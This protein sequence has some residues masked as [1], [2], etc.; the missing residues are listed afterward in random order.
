MQ[1][2]Q[3]APVHGAHVRGHAAPSLRIALSLPRLPRAILGTEPE[4]VLPRRA[5]WALSL[6]SSS[7]VGMRVRDRCSAE[8]R[9][10]EAPG[11]RSAGATLLKLAENN[12][13]IA[14]YEIAQHPRQ[15][16]RRSRRASRR[17]RSGWRERPITATSRP[18]TNLASALRDGRG[19]VQDYE[20][21][22]KWMQLAA[23]GGSGP[24]Q[25][26]LGMTY[27]GRASGSINNVKAYVWL[28]RCSRAGRAGCNRGA[29]RRVAAPYP[30][31]IAGSAAKCTACS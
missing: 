12:D 21:A 4:R 28:Q 26:A 14:E 20:E 23:E 13:S 31:R 19:T 8:E 25:L 18:S 24:A 30:H 10:G 6:L 15:R 27:A 3:F 11:S 1:E 7:S 9:T 16:L 22:R 17:S 2:L 5:S 29:R